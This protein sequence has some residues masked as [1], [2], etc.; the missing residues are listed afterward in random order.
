M[1]NQKNISQ[2]LFEI[3]LYKDIEISQQDSLHILNCIQGLG[4]QHLEPIDTYCAYCGT[5]STFQHQIENQI[6]KSSNSDFRSLLQKGT[7]KYF[8][9][10][11]KC[12]RNNSHDLILVFEKINNILVKIGQYP[13]RADIEKLNIKK[14]SK[15]LDD[16]MMREFSIGLGLF[17]HGVG[18]GSFVYLRRILEYLIEE[19]HKIAVKENNLDEEQYQKSRVIE[20]IEML[21]EYL[22]EI[23]VKN[24]SI[25]SIISKGIHELSEDECKEY[26]IP[27]KNV[28]E[29]V[30][31]EKVRQD[32]KEKLLEDTE[33]I[34]SSIH[35]K[36]NQG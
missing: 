16:K 26:F 21:S 9:I 18:I 2:E 14:Y 31:D 5:A 6:Y 25:Y 24:K 4:N 29:L 3:S 20:K 13:S 17:S 23:M 22:P 7:Q 30:L 36:L 12:A 19:S 28:I 32:E 33:K 8:T 34:I 10:F 15:V 35:N 11:Y 1:E 27:I